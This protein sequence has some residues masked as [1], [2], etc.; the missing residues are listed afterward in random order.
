MF[1]VDNYVY[2]L[3][4]FALDLELREKGAGSLN[5]AS[6]LAQLV[7]RNEVHVVALCLKLP[8]SG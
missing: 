4:A 5:P 3:R 8:Q 1:W 7:G 2:R 6:Q